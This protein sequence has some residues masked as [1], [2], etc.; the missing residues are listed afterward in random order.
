MRKALLSVMFGFGLLAA[1]CGG[2]DVGHSCTTNS[3][4][5]NGLSCN[6][7]QP[8]GYCTKGCSVEGSGTECPG[9]SVCS[10]Q[11]GGLLC[12]LVCQGQNDCRAEYECNGVSGSDQKTCRPK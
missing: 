9:G 5:S 6:T 10:S 3:D 1:G 7:N 11:G 8:G 12:A 2:T 4:C